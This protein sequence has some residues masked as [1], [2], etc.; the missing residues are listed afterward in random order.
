MEAINPIEDHF[1]VAM[2]MEREKRSKQY[3]LQQSTK[4]RRDQ[5]ESVLKELGYQ[6][7]DGAWQ[8]AEPH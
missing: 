4:G 8:L 3:K 5:A 2:R 1:Q 6:F 7:K